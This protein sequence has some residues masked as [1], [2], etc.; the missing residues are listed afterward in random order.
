ME[1][2][3]QMCEMA[4]KLVSTSSFSF[5][6]LKLSTKDIIVIL[7]DTLN[8]TSSPLRIFDPHAIRVPS[9]ALERHSIGSRVIVGV[10]NLVISST[11]A[12]LM[13]SPTINS[14]FTY[15][16]G[17]NNTSLV[18]LLL[19][20]SVMDNHYVHKIS[21]SFPKMVFSER[22]S[23]AIEVAI[24]DDIEST[25][26]VGRHTPKVVLLDIGAQ[27]VIL[28]GQFTKKMGMFDS[29]LRKSMWQNSHS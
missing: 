5:Q 24:I 9:N 6:D 10:H 17:A 27:P 7:K 13:G 2:Q 3:L 26:H 19:S 21:H 22:T 15:Q 25:I 28:G 18:D 4:Q 20:K 29:K 16:K 14:T 8:I 11:M 23:I 12:K 1:C